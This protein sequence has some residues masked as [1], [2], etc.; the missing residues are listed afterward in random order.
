MSSAV[1]ILTGAVLLLA[2]DSSDFITGQ[3]LA[4]DGGSGAG[5][6]IQWDEDDSQPG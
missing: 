1:R 2:S 3:T 4:V 5:W 6:V